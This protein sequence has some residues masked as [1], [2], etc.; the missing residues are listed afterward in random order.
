MLGV[1]AS[2][3]N[4]NQGTHTEG[5][6]SVQLTSFYLPV[7]L[8]ALDTANIICFFYKTSYLIEEV[9]CTEPSLTVSIP[10]FFYTLNLDRDSLLKG[11]REC[12]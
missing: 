4:R 9:N 2:L 11:R 12:G 7:R 6:G 1:V 10:S 8:D 5:K 3:L